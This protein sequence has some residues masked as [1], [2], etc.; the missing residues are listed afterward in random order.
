MRIELRGIVQFYDGGHKYVDV[1]VTNGRSDAY[2][3][4]RVGV[5]IVVN[6]GMILK[7]L[8]DFYGMPPGHIIWPGHIKAVD[9]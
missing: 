2:E 5:D 7:F 9:I 8:G 3:S 6:R 4:H 1:V